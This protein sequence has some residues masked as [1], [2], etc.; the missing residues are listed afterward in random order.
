[1]IEILSLPFMQKAFIAGIMLAAPLAFLGVYSTLKKASF[2]GDGVAHASL[3]GIALGILTG[4]SPFGMAIIVG[5]LFGAGVY[6]LERKTSVSSD[7]IIGILFTGGMALGIILL[8]L[9]QGYQPELISFLFGNILTIHASDLVLI[10][11]L[12]V[13]IIVFLSI[14]YRRLALLVLDKDEAWLTG[15]PT[16]GLELVFYVVLSISIVLGVKLLGIILVSA[17]LIIPAASAKLLSKSFRKLVLLSILIGE[18]VVIGGLILSYYLDFPSG[19]VIILTGV[20]LFCLIAAWD[21]F[22]KITKEK[23]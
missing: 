22:R 20:G 10:I 16:S 9:K 11:G 7:S 6:F 5:A 21:G 23:S 8:N 2:F 18:I 1:M 4:V 17:L 19:A 14:V 3:S 15:I 13:G 12:G